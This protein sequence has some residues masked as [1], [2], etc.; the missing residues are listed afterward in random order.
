MLANFK[1]KNIMSEKNLS[2]ITKIVLFIIGLGLLHTAGELANGFGLISDVFTLLGVYQLFIISTNSEARAT[3][4]KNAQSLIEADALESF[5]V[6]IKSF[7]SGNNIIANIDESL[8]Q[9]II[10]PPVDINL[11]NTENMNKL[12]DDVITK[13]S[14][15]ETDLNNLESIND[16]YLELLT[17]PTK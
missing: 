13:L 8:L 2:T 17:R 14:E 9:D 16:A 7:F 5:I 11:T 4:F 6:Y 3:I 12:E 1:F 10:I 15:E